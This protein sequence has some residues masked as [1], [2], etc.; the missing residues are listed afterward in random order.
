MVI[1]MNENDRYFK[2]DENTVIHRLL[3]GM[4][5]VSGGHGKIDPTS[6]IQD[7]HNYADNGF[8]TWD[9]ADHYG[10]AEDFIKI[11]RSSLREQNKLEELEKSKFFT[12]WVPRP[13]RMKKKTVE[14][15]INISRNR[16]GMETL[17]MLQF[18][19][20]DYNNSQYL[21]ALN[22]L[23]D[24]K[25]D[26]W[27]SHLSL[28]NFDTKRIETILDHG[29]KITSNQAQYSLIDT[30]PSRLMTPLFEKEQIYIFAYGTL[31]GGFLSSKYLGVDEPSYWSLGTASL[32]KYKNM[33]DRWGGWSLFQD[34][35]AV[36]KQIAEKH[37]VSI[38]NVATRYVLEQP[39]VAGVIVGARLG[40][41]NHIEDNLGVFSFSLDDRDY[42]QI[43]K[44]LKRSNDL[45][46]IIGDCGD[47]YRD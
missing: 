14:K 37:K 6:A 44:V 1:N 5:Q 41:A 24:L 40:I 38:A 17:D 4:W 31:A 10:P 3:N 12:K 20:W 45:L 11:F 47:E 30:R 9:L 36:L 8:F 43:G 18:H 25:E 21:D 19:W 23:Q 7:M 15:A 42:M 33:I 39:M 32:R 27:I 28:T 34:L 22:H 29:I 26:G 46:E 35:L 2:L 13:Q 16:M